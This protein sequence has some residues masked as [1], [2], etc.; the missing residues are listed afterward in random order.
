MATSDKSAQ[1]ANLPKTMIFGLGQ[2]K[3]S[4]DCNVHSF[5][6]VSTVQCHPLK[7]EAIKYFINQFQ[8]RSSRLGPKGTDSEGIDG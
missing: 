2:M 5:Y 4:G 1:F 6:A 3:T 7:S 8:F